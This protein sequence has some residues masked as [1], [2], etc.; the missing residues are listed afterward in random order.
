MGYGGS[1]DRWQILARLQAQGESRGEIAH[2]GWAEHS[3]GRFLKEGRAV[4]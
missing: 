4:G 2:G 3:S 1:R